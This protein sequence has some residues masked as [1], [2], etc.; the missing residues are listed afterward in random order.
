MKKTQLIL[1][2]TDISSLGY[3]AAAP[4]APVERGADTTTTTGFINRWQSN[5]TWYNVNLRSVLGGLYKEGGKYNLKLE[6]I[7]FSLTSNLTTYTAIENNRAFNVFIS[8]FPFMSSYSVSGGLRNESL[9][10]TVRVP[11]GAQH[12]MFNYSNNE[13]T[14]D[15]AKLNGIN[16]VD[17]TIQYRDLLLNS[18]EPIGGTN[19]VAYPNAQFVFSIYQV[20]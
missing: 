11:S 5:M 9:L 17:I 19:T 20:E 7:C 8:G 4:N 16:N 14:F 1:R 2:S 15:L 6:S 10:S 3:N 13:L 18:T 12:Y